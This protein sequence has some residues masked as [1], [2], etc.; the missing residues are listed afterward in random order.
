MHCI[1][2]NNETSIPTSFTHDKDTSNITTFIWKIAAFKTI[3]NCIFTNTM[4]INM[5]V[6][7]ITHQWVGV[8]EQPFHS[9]S[10]GTQSSSQLTSHKISH[11]LLF[12]LNKNYYTPIQNTK[13]IHLG[14]QKKFNFF[15]LKLNKNKI[16]L[17]KKH[18]QKSP[19]KA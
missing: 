14:T 1:S 11:H 7:V 8:K 2:N 9:S 17:Q 15:P 18:Q 6:K 19:S 13:K 10:Q 12:I 16:Q 3:K 4:S 5:V